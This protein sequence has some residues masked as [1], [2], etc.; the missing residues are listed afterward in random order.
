MSYPRGNLFIPGPAGPLECI[1]WEAEGASRWAVIS[2]GHPLHGGVMHFKVLH[3]A[4]RVLQS[5]GFN[6]LRYN[7]R[8]VGGSAGAF[9]GT[10]GEGEED[11]RAVLRH[12][13]ER[14]S[15]RD[16]L[17]AGF[18]FGAWISARVG[19]ADPRVRSLLLLG[20]AGRALDD[21]AMRACPRPAALVQ[22]DRDQF[23]PWEKVEELASSLPRARLF[24][25]EGADHFFKDR[26]A[27]LERA[28][29]EAAA[30]LDRS[31]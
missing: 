30:H 7:F 31:P 5:A 2:H 22:G 8:G 6:V 24:R 15:A 29:G 10:P 4:A 3:R 20:L 17:L 16:F 26:L 13:E 14:R 12:L 21:E 11:L 18:S 1:A 27:E 19:C 25:I 23:A 28:V 9:L